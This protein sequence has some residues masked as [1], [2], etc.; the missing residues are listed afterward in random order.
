MRSSKKGASEMFME[1]AVII[2]VLAVVGF[3]ISKTLLRTSPS[4]NVLFGN[5]DEVERQLAGKIVMCWSSNTGKPSWQSCGEFPTTLTGATN[6]ST[7]HV[8]Q[9]AGCGCKVNWRVEGN[10]T[11]TLIN[12]DGFNRQVSV[13]LIHE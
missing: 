4:A 3:M 9:I 10:F 6:I 2:V 5:S 11:K 1:M 13:E 7:A 8:E 12:Y